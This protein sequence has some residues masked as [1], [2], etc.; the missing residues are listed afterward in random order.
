MFFLFTKRSE[1]KNKNK[2]Q[3]R[4]TQTIKATTIFDELRRVVVARVCLFMC[5][6]ECL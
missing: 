4:K 1:A 6:I 5:F 2:R 3:K